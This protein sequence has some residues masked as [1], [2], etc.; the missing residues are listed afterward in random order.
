VTTREH[1]LV[2]PIGVVVDLLGAVDTGL[3][4]DA[5]AAV[6]GAVAGGRAKRRR[7]ALALLDNPSVLTSG[8]SPAPSA[9]GELLLALRRGG[10][11]GISGPYCAGCGRAVTSIQRRGEDWYCT[12]CFTRPQP[13]ASCGHPRYVASRDRQGQPRCGQCPDE[14]SRDPLAALVTAIRT[15]DA[16]LPPAAVAEVI[17]RTVSKPGHRL[18]LAWIIEDDPALLTGEGARAP[19]PALLRLIDALGAAG[20]VGIVPP[21]CPLCLRVMALSK[22]KDGQRIC[23]ACSARDRAVTC[24]RCG[25]A[26]EPAARDEQGRPLCPTCLVNTPI[27]LEPCRSCGR[28]RRVSVRTTDGPLCET[29]RP[30]QNGTCTICGRTGPCLISKTTGR[31]WCRACKQRRALCVDC[32]RRAQIR[33][34]TRA[35]PRCGPCAVPDP[36]L[37]RSCPSCG[38]T[39]RL[40]TGPCSRCNLHQQLDEL[41]SGPNSGVPPQLR[42]LHDA[43]AQ[44]AWPATVLSWLSKD[45]VRGLLAELAAGRRPLTHTTL[46]ELPPSKT[47]AHLRAV[48]VATGSIPERDE[49]LAGLERWVAGAVATY[50]D[51]DQRQLLHRYAVW[52]LLRRLRGRNRTTHATYQQATVIRRRV[53]AAATLLEW[54]TTRELTLATCRQDHLDQWITSDHVPGRREAGHFVRW[55]ISAR[56]T[57]RDLS[58]PAT[59]WA[60]P[61]GV[62]NAEHRWSVARRLL[63]D[64][65]LKAEDRVAGLLLLLY[66][67][68]PATISRLTT[69]QVEH[70]DTGTVLLHLG[71]TP[72]VLPEPLATLTLKLVATRTGHAVIGADI[73]TPWLFPGG[74]PGHPV[75]AYQMG[76]RL[77]SLDIQP[78]TARS[79]ALLQL[80]TELPAAILARTLG[81]HIAVA[82]AW[83]RAAAADWTTYAAELARRRTTPTP[84]QQSS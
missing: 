64:D 19:V 17:Q 3:T 10:A 51:P 26:R 44:V 70:Q 27:N 79:T 8:R 38:T 28:R 6:V 46:D 71:S 31:P 24:A 12:G 48:L 61:T 69:S 9:V 36:G 37:W 43:L 65:T 1:A 16:S 15:V 2:D 57:R 4:A 47:L 40:T 76:Q 75:S 68:R 52:H 29:C 30:W 5:V 42:L 33:A 74:R 23:R 63:H 18:R 72:V 84:P 56:L 13:C 25:T 20:A 21:A 73:A 55:A 22:K 34:G 78:A 81:I 32:G 82:V 66:A 80:A 83:Q 53:G 49:H 14:D 50:T 59:R 35:A 77:H 41:L 58:F 11:A 60:G 45:A 67:Q 7:L 62:I 39:Q 54:L